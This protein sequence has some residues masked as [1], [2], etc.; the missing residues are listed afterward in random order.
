[1]QEVFAVNIIGPKGDTE[2]IL[3]NSLYLECSNDD[4]F[5]ATSKKSIHFRVE[6]EI[7][8]AK[9]LEEISAA[10]FKNHKLKKGSTYFLKIGEKIQI[11][12]SFIILKNRGLNNNLISDLIPPIPK[13]E[14]NEENFEKEKIYSEK[15]SEI[16]KIE[17]HPEKITNISLESIENLAEETLLKDQEL[18]KKKEQ[19]NDSSND[20]IGAIHRFFSIFTTFILCLFLYQ[21][22]DFKLF[23]DTV[24]KIYFNLEPF[25]GL[26]VEK[27]IWIDIIK[28]LLIFVSVEFVSRILFSVSLPLF[29]S[30]VTTPGKFA[31][32][33]IKGLLRLPFDLLSTFFPLFDIPVLLGKKSAKE[34]LFNSP[35]KYRSRL[36]KNISIFLQAIL[37]TSILFTPFVLN[38]G[39][40]YKQVHIREKKERSLKDTGVE[41]ISHRNNFLAINNK[42]SKGKFLFVN[43]S[44]LDIY[45]IFESKK[46]NYENLK[47]YVKKVPFFN[48]FYPFLSEYFIN[49]KENKKLRED[50]LRFFNTSLNANMIDFNDLFSFRTISS[51]GTPDL[52]KY[53][54]LE[55]RKMIKIT[56][57]TRALIEKEKDIIVFFDRDALKVFE[58]KKDVKE[59]NSS[60]I[61]IA[62][63]LEGMSDEMSKTA[64][65]RKVFKN[66]SLDFFLQGNEI[67][68]ILEKNGSPHKKSIYNKFISKTIES[69]ELKGLFFNNKSKLLLEKMRF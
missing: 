57:F 43:K 35:V 56:K 21:Y 14:K 66:K 33:R 17:N 69:A 1:M 36:F 27:N 39:F 12:K 40:D 30:G 15:R 20:I 32:K 42:L 11:G 18:M 31:A 24:E 26:R 55:Q 64:F 34:V 5:P 9:I 37:F 61:E 68:K 49:L 58:I 7:V 54:N 22:F 29:F 13:K 67:K 60:F 46:I 28:V 48:Y 38:D 3:N 19:I 51:F 23:N 52:F 45:N 59:K 2:L 41:G 50:A 63:F 62:L 47:G 4:I 8:T 25:L 10:N 44:N 16:E 6:K 53:L 65:N